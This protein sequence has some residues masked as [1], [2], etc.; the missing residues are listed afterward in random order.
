MPRHP[1][2]AGIIHQFGSQCNVAC[3]RAATAR[4]Q[5]AQALWSR[6][7]KRLDGSGEV[8][9]FGDFCVVEISRHA[10]IQIGRE[11]NR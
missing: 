10:G 3:N 5:E 7:P 11:L 9:P 8:I 6:S 4:Y 2:S 1:I